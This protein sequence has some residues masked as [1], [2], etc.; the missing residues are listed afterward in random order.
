MKEELLKAP[1]GCAKWVCDPEL[2]GSAVS[3][4]GGVDSAAAHRTPALKTSDL[5]SLYS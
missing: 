1:G 4:E 5:T 2:K 3:R